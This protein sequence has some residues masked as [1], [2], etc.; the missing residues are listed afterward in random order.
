MNKGVNMAGRVS[1]GA[2]KGSTVH[3]PE[4]FRP[5]TIGNCEI[6][7][8]IVMAPM[9]TLFSMD[10][11][12]Y[13]NDQI[14]A[15]YAA[16]ARNGTGMIVTE[17]VLGTR[18][19]SR[20]PY[21]TNLHLFD[22]T[23]VP[24]LSELVE[25][26]H[27]FGSRT[28]IQLSIGFGRQGHSPEHEAPPAPSPI[29]YSHE[30][31]DPLAMIPQGLLEKIMQN[32]SYI[33]PRLPTMVH[34]DTPREMSVEEI[35]SEIAEF[36]RSCVLAALAGF[37]GI[38]LHAPHG[39]LEHQF[40]SPRTNKRRDEYGGSLENRM[41][42]VLEVYGEARR[43]VGDNFPIGIR[44]S[45][46]EHLPDGIHHDELQ[47]V[48]KRL[49]EL[50]IDYVHLSDGSYEALKW[51]FPDEDNLHLLE[52]AQGFKAQLP[53][54][55]PV[56]SVSIHDPETAAWAIREGKADM[57]SLGRQLLADPAWARKARE[58][59]KVRRCLRCNDCLMRTSMCLPVRCRI[60]PD[61][62]W[63]RYI[64][65]YRRPR[66]PRDR[67]TVSVPDLGPQLPQPGE[68]DGEAARGE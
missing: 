9:N 61:L 10:N 30:G 29:P 44:L 13:V 42:F 16:R 34:A 27:A 41:R 5:I 25:T 1:K 67:Q 52:E 6:P 11:R 21:T 36:G 19:A 8:R 57:I 49:G 18:M 59:R 47:Q 48:V 28:F 23:H 3:Y 38:E 56:I 33:D 65:E 35:R 12:G 7:N 32:P 31:L 24:G 45:G 51:F 54:G 20:F 55:V 4:L 50:G 37:D 62:G 63:E 26:I 40:L 60:N 53:E 66:R 68:A 46:D 2:G 58:G 43:M 22:T 14:L 15:Y 64:E 17:C 39:Y